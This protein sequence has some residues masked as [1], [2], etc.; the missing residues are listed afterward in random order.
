MV[1]T[2]QR[3]SHHQ[4]R[5]LPAWHLMVENTGVRR[6]Y[7]CLETTVQHPDLAPVEVKGLDITV[8]DPS[9]KASLLEC[10][11]DSTHGGL[12]GQARHT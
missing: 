11:R 6:P 7:V 8:S 1:V 10:S 4:V 9:S 12:R 2:V 3:I 5:I